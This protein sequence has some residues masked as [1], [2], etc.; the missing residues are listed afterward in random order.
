MSRTII[1]NANLV[2]G[3]QPPRADCSVVV[4]GERIAS[5]TSEEI[6]GRDGDAVLDLGGKT[7]MPGMTVGHFHAEYGYLD[8]ARINEQYIGSEQ[9]PGLL[10]LV[11]ANSVRNALYSGYTG[12]VGGACSNQIDAVLKMA[13]ADGVIEGPRIV[14]ASRHINT[15]GHDNDR[16]PWWKDQRNFGAE[17]MVDGPIEFR[18]AVRTEIKLGAEIIKLFPTGG[19]GIPQSEEIKGLTDDELSAAVEAAHQRGAMVRAHC[20]WRDD[21]LKCIDFGV[22]VIDHGDQIDDKVVAAMVDADTF[23]IPS[24]LFLERLLEASPDQATPEQVATAAEWENLCEMLPRANAAGVKIVPGDDYGLAFLPHT[25]GYYSKE[26]TL[27]VDKVGIPAVDVLGWTC[28]NGAELRRVG[29]DAGT[30]E[31]GKLADLVVVD[32]D[33]TVDISVLED[34]DNLRLVMLGGEYVKNTL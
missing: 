6:V 21:I 14:A 12:M 5:V 7:L 27:Y 9:P 10:M 3:R 28:R 25:P 13:I 17:V 31:T 19:H 30:I 33:P 22:D 8:L 1:K 26:L 15:T 34:V 29:S 4:E 24:M 32:G 20:V 11:A 2:D 16:A 18:K 23:W